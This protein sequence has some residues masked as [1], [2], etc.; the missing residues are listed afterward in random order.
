MFIKYCGKTL[1]GFTLI[2]ILGELRDMKEKCPAFEDD[3]S[4]SEQVIWHSV[5]KVCHWTPGHVL[6]ALQRIHKAQ[7]QVSCFV[8]WR[9]ECP[10]KNQS[11]WTKANELLLSMWKYFFRQSFR[12][13]WCTWSANSKRKCLK[14]FN[15]SKLI[16]LSHIMK[17]HLWLT[18]AV[19]ILR[20]V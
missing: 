20:H 16:R 19:L 11:A 6:F 4:R 7:G 14:C 17:V 15:S 12:L 2:V 5:R 18:Q 10:V 1:G 9:W 3:V 8:V 13:Q